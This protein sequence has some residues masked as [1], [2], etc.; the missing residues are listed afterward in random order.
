MARL[1]E[2]L[3]GADAQGIPRIE[4][5]VEEFPDDP[6][7]HFLLG[8]VLAGQR[9]YEEAH[10]AMRMAID[11][12]PDYALARFQ[13]GFLELTSG[14]PTSAEA[15]WG[16][17]DQLVPGHPLRLFANGLR[18]LARDEFGPAVDLLRQGIAANTE[19][20]EVN[21]DMQLIINKVTESGDQPAGEAT[22]STHMLLQQ[23]AARTT[24]H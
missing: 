22:S 17:L 9:R 8:S 18:H 7:L 19:L 12:A 20:P 16:P 23:Y 5:L 2:S 6:R 14:D 4:Q 13:L 21:A 1:V 24:R 10:N 11:V 15:T 3:K